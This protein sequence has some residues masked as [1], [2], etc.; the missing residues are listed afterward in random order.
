MMNDDIPDF[1]FFTDIYDAFERD[2]YRIPYSKA[3][4]QSRFANA[5]QDNFFS[6]SIVDISIKLQ[7]YSVDISL[8]TIN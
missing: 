4:G 2:A 3:I 5:L 6:N 8:I 1:F 7:V